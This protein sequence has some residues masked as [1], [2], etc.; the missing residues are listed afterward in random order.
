MFEMVQ[1]TTRIRMHNA[2]TQKHYHY[3]LHHTTI[4][5]ASKT[6]TARRKASTLARPRPRSRGGSQARL[7]ALARLCVEAHRVEL[8]LRGGRAEAG[9]PCVLRSGA[10]VPIQAATEPRRYAEEGRAQRRILGQKKRVQMGASDGAEE[11]VNT[12]ASSFAVPRRSRGAP[13]STSQTL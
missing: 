13:S 2:A 8:L 5:L 1:Y 9:H 11:D 3:L 4:M 10:Q 7:A 12:C 6:A